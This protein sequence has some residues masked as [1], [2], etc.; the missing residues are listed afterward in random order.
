MKAKLHFSD[1]EHRKH[2][3][4]AGCK[5]TAIYVVP[6]FIAQGWCNLCR[7]VAFGPKPEKAKAESPEFKNPCDKA[8]LTY[9]KP[10]GSR[11]S[12]W[13]RL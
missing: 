2:C 12:K 9:A 4:Q 5:H 7:A 1:A 8:R 13:M 3:K 10:P 11:G 6:R